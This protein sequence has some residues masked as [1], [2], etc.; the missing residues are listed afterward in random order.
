MP[1]IDPL[2]MPPQ[3]G[4]KSAAAIQAESNQAKA[5]LEEV[6]GPATNSIHHKANVG[7]RRPFLKK[8]SI[9]KWKMAPEEVYKKLVGEG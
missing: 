4:P 3:R 5:E 6:K 8:L 1:Y 7:A 9:H 2:M